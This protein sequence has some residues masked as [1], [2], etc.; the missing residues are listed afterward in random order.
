MLNGFTEY[1][2]AELAPTTGHPAVGL[3]VVAIPSSGHDSVTTAVAQDKWCKSFLTGIA[4]TMGAGSTGSFAL[5]HQAIGHMEGYITASPGCQLLCG[6]GTHK[7]AG[8]VTF[9]GPWGACILQ[10]QPATSMYRSKGLGSSRR[11]PGDRTQGY[12]R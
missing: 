2:L 10:G 6:S 1:G 5:K 8:S 12:T 7:L 9:R 4:L 3:D 11:S